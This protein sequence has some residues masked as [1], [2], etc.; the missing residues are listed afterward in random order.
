MITES[1]LALLEPSELPAFARGGGVLTPVTGLGDTIL[2]RLE[3]SGRFTFESEII[4]GKEDR[5]TR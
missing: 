5:K 2:A 3:D 1:A 4:S